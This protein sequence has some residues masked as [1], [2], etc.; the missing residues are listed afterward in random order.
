MTPF[1]KPFKIDRIIFTYLIPVLPL[2]T[3]WD[4]VVSVLRTYTVTELKQMI[5]KLKNNELFDW[6][7]DVAKGKQ[8]EILYLLGTPVK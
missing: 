3:L 1:I 7:V 8:N 5:I 4:G 6:E 2:L